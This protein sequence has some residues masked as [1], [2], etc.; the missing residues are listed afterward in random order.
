MVIIHGHVHR[1]STKQVMTMEMVTIH[2]LLPHRWSLYTGYCHTGGQKEQVLS[3]VYNR[4]VIKMVT[5]DSLLIYEDDGV[6]M[7]TIHTVGPCLDMV[8][9]ERLLLSVPIIM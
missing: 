9:L 2:S 4:Q 1:N 8:T 7:V 6:E 3:D 5:T